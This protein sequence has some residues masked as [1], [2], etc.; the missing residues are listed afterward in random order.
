MIVTGKKPHKVPD[1]RLL[2]ILFNRFL[3][4]NGIEI[5]SETDIPVA[6]KLFAESVEYCLR[7]AWEKY[8]D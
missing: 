8:N 7:E 2:N 5:E 1:M 6:I 4:K 3:H